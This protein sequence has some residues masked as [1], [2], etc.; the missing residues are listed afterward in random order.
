MKWVI[1]GLTIAAV[2]GCT[3]HYY[4][5]QG[6][7]VRIHLKKNAQEVYFDAVSIDRLG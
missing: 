5:T 2:A 3:T 6:D 4:T 7:L 1:L